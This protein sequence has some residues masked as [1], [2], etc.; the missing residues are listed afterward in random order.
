MYEE[1]VGVFLKRKQGI[2][3]LEGTVVMAKVCL[4]S[5]GFQGP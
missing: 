2:I 4:P 1:G 5:A 3:R